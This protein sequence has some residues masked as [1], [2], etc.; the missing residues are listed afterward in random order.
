[1]IVMIIIMIIII[2]SNNNNNNNTN[3]NSNITNYKN[4]ASSLGGSFG[5][6]LP[7]ASLRRS[8]VHGQKP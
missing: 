2:H 5:R 6:R 3:I 4:D 8:G 1:M 7:P